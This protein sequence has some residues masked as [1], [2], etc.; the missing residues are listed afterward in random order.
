MFLEVSSVN[1]EFII[2]GKKRAMVMAT[3]CDWSNSK[4]NKGCHPQ[5]NLIQIC[6]FQKGGGVMSKTNLLKKL[7]AL[8]MF[9]QFL[10]RI[11]EDDK[12]PKNLEELWFV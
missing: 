4:H 10:S 7:F 3:G 1:L 12:S 5:K 8:F 11:W 6:F 9:G 2:L